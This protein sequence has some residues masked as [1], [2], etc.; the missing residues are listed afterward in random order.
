[1]IWEPNQA[2]GRN[3]TEVCVLRIGKHDIMSSKTEAIHYHSRDK[4]RAS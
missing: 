1:M 3:A 4:F 2:R